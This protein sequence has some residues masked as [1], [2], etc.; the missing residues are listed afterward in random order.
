MLPT[1]PRSWGW[2]A[3]GVVVTGVVV[4]YLASQPAPVAERLRYQSEDTPTAVAPLPP[5]G[6]QVEGRTY[7]SA[8]SHAY[9]GAGTPVLF[10][11]TLTVRNVD[12]VHPLVLRRV[13][14]HATDGER[15]RSLLERERVL[16]P[17]GTAELFI[18]REDEA[19]GPGANFVVEWRIP[20]GAHRPLSEAVM[21]G[22][23]GPTGYSF[24]TVGVDV[25]DHASTPSVP[26][27][28]ASTEPP[29]ETP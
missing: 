6:A 3:G 15:L 4:Y 25:S 26:Q 24:V 14:Y 1:E 10:A 2:I 20:Q 27:P 9:V 22:S 8:Y 18:E 7:V 23:A 12:P 29:S 13:D 21:L 16:P 11:I 28:S 17:L 5:E 19:G